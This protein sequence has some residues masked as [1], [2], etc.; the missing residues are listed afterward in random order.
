VQLPTACQASLVRIHIFGRGDI[1]ALGLRV[2]RK[3]RQ[4]GADYA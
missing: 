1:H 4:L 2:L 3:G